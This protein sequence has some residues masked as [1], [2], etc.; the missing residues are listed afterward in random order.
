MPVEPV[1]CSR[2]ASEKCTD[3]ITCHHLAHVPATPARWSPGVDRYLEVAE[4]IRREVPGVFAEQFGDAAKDAGLD[5]H[6]LVYLIVF[7]QA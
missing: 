6:A 5:H 7:V 3:S 2:Q 4:A 1:I